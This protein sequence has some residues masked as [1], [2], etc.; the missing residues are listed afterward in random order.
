MLL[1]AALLIGSASAQSLSV[2]FSRLQDHPSLEAARSQLK[3]AETQAAGTRTLYGVQGRA[4]YNWAELDAQPPLPRSADGLSASIDLTLKPLPFGDNADAVARAELAVQQA[5][6][7]YRQALATLEAQALQAAYQLQLAGEALTVARSGEQTA[8]ASLEAARVQAERGAIPTADL[9]SA[10]TAYREAQERL[11]SAEENVTLAEVSLRSLVG[12][13]T[14]GPVEL[15]ALPARTSTP[16]ELR[17]RIALEQAR[18]AL[19]SAQRGVIPTASLSYT[20]YATDTSSFG[21]SVDSRNLAPKLNYSFEDPR[22]S[23]LGSSSPKIRQTVTLGV[24]FDFSPATYANLD[25]AQ[26][27]LRAA[28]A[29]LEAARRSADLQATSLE[30]AYRQAER[31]I[32]LKTQAVSDAAQALSEAQERQRLGLLSPLA[33]LRASAELAQARLALQ[34]AQFDRLGKLLDIYRHYALPLSE[35]KK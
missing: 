4:G 16:E 15:P 29:D 33:V 7:G 25:A 14:P 30:V 22:Q 1:S 18:I 6:L 20:N 31:Q 26:T 2:F 34:Q 23:T 11:R 17:A 9:R 27:S 35:V 32:D 28:E 13:A 3:A 5:R 24:A 8:R 10:E 19:N 12:D 21:L